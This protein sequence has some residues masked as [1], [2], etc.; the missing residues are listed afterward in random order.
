MNTQTIQM[1]TFCCN[2]AVHSQH[3]SSPC[4]VRDRNQS[5]HPRQVHLGG[6]DGQDD[7]RP[8]Q[9]GHGQ[10]QEGHWGAGGDQSDQTDQAV[11]EVSHGEPGGR[12]QG[13]DREQ[14]RQRAGHWPGWHT[15]G[16]FYLHKVFMSYLYK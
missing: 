6:Q 14:Q 1:I 5:H 9:A 15:R 7:P 12:H 16:G 4:P 2:I 3:S 13:S 10:A 8:G 11:D